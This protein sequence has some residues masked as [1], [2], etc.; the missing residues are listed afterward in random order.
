VHTDDIAW[1]YS[2]CGWAELLINGVLIPARSGEPVSYRPPPW[3]ERKR[4]G[5]IEVPL[6]CSLL[7]I[8]GVGAARRECAPLIDATIW[9]QSDEREM[10]RRNLGRVGHPDGMP[11]EQDHRE[12]M[13]EEIPFQAG[14]RPW[15]RAG[16]IVCGTP[17]IPFDPA[18]ELVIAPPMAS[19]G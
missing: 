17:Q 15:E 1:W 3:D 13:A 9:V 18:T 14:H 4:P 6:G 16:L 8:E 7:I 11:T 2:R 10:E 19:S 5:A 12:W